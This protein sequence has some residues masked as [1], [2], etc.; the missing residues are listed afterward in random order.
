MC[1]PLIVIH[2]LNRQGESVYCML[3][4][5]LNY[6]SLLSI[7]SDI[8]FFK[9]FIVGGFIRANLEREQPGEYEHPLKHAL[10]FESLLNSWLGKMFRMDSFSQCHLNSKL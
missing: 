10:H 1:I 5:I 4:H 6:Q 3:K 2:D 8:F 9:L 7:C